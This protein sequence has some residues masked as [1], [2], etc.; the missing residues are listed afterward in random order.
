[1][2]PETRERKKPEQFITQPAAN[3]KKQTGCGKMMADR[4]RESRVNKKKKEV[5]EKLNDLR[6]RLMFEIEN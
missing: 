1:M 4:K 5:F 3:S 6:R 2:K